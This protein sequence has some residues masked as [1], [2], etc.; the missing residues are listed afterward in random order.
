[1]IGIKNHGAP[2]SS[3]KVVQRLLT[4]TKNRQLHICRINFRCFQNIVNS[5]FLLLKVKFQLSEFHWVFQRWQDL[6]FEYNHHTRIAKV[7]WVTYLNISMNLPVFLAG[8]RE[9]TTLPKKLPPKKRAQFYPYLTGKLTVP[10]LRSPNLPLFQGT[11]LPGFRENS[12]TQ[13]LEIERNTLQGINISHLGKRKI[14]FKMPFLGDMLVP[15]R[16]CRWFEIYHGVL[17]PNPWSFFSKKPKGWYVSF[18]FFKGW[19]L[20]SGFFLFFF[21]GGGKKT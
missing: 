16:V 7:T 5:I 19:W 4:H 6:N 10:L 12:F 13:R 9:V 20:P 8:G 15:W 1:M 11:R 18:G 14:I 2:L 3:K 21:F 17:F